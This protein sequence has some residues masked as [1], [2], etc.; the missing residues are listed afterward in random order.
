[1]IIGAA[2]I[3]GPDNV[4]RPRPKIWVRYESDLGERHAVDFENGV[5][6]VQILLKRT[7]NPG[8]AKVL[9]H[10]VQ[11]VGNLILR[12]SDDPA[13]MVEAKK[14]ALKPE[15]PEVYA[16]LTEKLPHRESRHYVRSVL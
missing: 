14:S 2:G 8:H 12:E 3:W 5:A 15:A 11:G 1:M 10:L 16:R 6:S 9:A 7:D 4:W 13:D